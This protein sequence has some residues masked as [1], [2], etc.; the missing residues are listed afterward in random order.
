MRIFLLLMSCIFLSACGG[1]GGGSSGGSSTADS[2]TPVVTPSPPPP[3]IMVTTA[4]HGKIT[5]S[6][7]NRRRNS[8]AGTYYSAS[9]FSQQPGLKLINAHEALANLRLKRGSAAVAAPGTGVKVG[10]IDTGIDQS[11]P[12]FDQTLVTETLISGAS[13]ELTTTFSDVDYFSHGTAVASVI[14]SRKSNTV[15]TDTDI[16]S[17]HFHGVAWGST[18]RVTAIPLGTAGSIYTPVSLSDLRNGNSYWPTIFSNEITNNVD[19]LNLSFGASGTIEAYS[20]QDIR[21][22][23]NNA[24]STIAQAGSS[25][26]TIFVWAAGNAANDS[27]CNA[28]GRTN[29]CRDNKPNADSPEIY[30]GMMA[31]IQELQGH[32]IAVVSVDSSGTISNFSNRCGIAAKWCIAAPG[33]GIK[34]VYFGAAEDPN[35][36]GQV[37]ATHVR[38]GIATSRGTSFAAP[39][40]TG[41]L[42]LMKDVFRGQLSNTQLVT[43]L[44]A[45]A[46]NRGKYATTATYGQGLM[47]LSAATSIV[48]NPVITT[49]T[50]VGSNGFSLSDTS[51]QLGLAFG[52]SLQQALIGQ[53]VMALDQQYAPFWFDLGSFVGNVRS[54]QLSNDLQI[55][56]TE[57]IHSHSAGFGARTWNYV[58]SLPISGSATSI[59]WMNF[60]KGA[61]SSHLGLASGALA[62]SFRPGSDSVITTFASADNQAQ[63]LP[64]S[65]LLMSY[66][67]SR[68]FPSYMTLG[69]ISESES[70]LRSRSSGAFGSV[71]ANSVFFGAGISARIGRWEVSGEAE[72]GV[73]NPKIRSAMIEKMSSL[74]TTAF[75]MRGK[76]QLDSH[77]SLA[78]DVSQNLRV[79]SGNAKLSVPIARSHEGQVI[80]VKQDTELTPSGRQIDFSMRWDHSLNSRGHFSLESTV[81]K[82]PGHV[83]DAKP[84]SR[85]IAAWSQRF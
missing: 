80:H 40:V 55:F 47:D 58:P 85:V 39:F 22:N 64:V 82:D 44:F 50:S 5:L 12:A 29:A 25:R 57:N 74:G 3:K 31:R 59:G 32:S 37:S 62:A 26:K 36:P 67:P 81:S 76:R 72:A 13:D 23:F 38:R 8:L 9:T 11:S 27:S 33:E 20:E 45:T 73:F 6:E 52:D 60:A 1:G 7:Y 65:G 46:N 16:Q 28:N 78:F 77:N 4:E 15:W 61:S 83:R 79:E 35:N 84:Q 2:P 56:L 66:T 48:G 30:A 63:S 53:E 34:I 17:K 42:A 18:L 70:M 68:K 49:G 19:F 14:G 21:S 75:S 51:L 24:I 54:S 69:A 10:V 41:G 71:T 43:R